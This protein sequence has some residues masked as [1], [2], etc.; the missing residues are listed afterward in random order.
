MH[1]LEER[2]HN[3]TTSICSADTCPTEK[4]HL[5]GDLE[6]ANT[7]IKEFQVKINNLENE[8]SSLITAIK[9]I[10]EDNSNTPGTNHFANKDGMGSN[11]TWVEV[12]KNKRK[13]RKA[14]KLPENSTGNKPQS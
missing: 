10:Q 4:N 3:E 8:K 12:G 14:E 7:L 1:R 5:T 9:I 11:P 6:A 2:K 13:Q